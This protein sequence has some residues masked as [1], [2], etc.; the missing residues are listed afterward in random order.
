MLDSLFHL[1]NLLRLFELPRFDNVSKIIR[2]TLLESNSTVEKV[3]ALAKEK[4]LSAMLLAFRDIETTA[5]T[6]AVERVL[7]KSSI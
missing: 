7:K 3:F 1:F 5:K 2:G 4:C 6:T